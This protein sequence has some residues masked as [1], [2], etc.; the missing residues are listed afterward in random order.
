[1]S[2]NSIM[3]FRCVAISEERPIRKLGNWLGSTWGT[4]IFDQLLR[5]LKLFV[6]ACQPKLR[7]FVRRYVPVA[8]LRATGTV[9]YVF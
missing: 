8:S 5:P 3:T 6:A 4:T 1:M 7:G 2:F 9:S